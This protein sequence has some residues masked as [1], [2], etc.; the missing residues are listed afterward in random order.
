MFVNAETAAYFP[1]LAGD[2]KRVSAAKR[3]P[4]SRAA[5]AA[6]PTGAKPQMT[7][8]LHKGVRGLLGVRDGGTY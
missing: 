6:S 1:P 3:P 5:F 4:R 8:P 2:P 7:T